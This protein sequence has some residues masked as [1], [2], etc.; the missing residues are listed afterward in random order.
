M[1]QK[2]YECYRYSDEIIVKS[3]DLK[4]HNGVMSFGHEKQHSTHN[5]FTIRLKKRLSKLSL[6]FCEQPEVKKTNQSVQPVEGISNSRTLSTL[7]TS[8]WNKSKK[9]L[10]SS[11][12]TVGVADIVMAKMSTYSPWPA[13][14]QNISTNKK[15]VSVYFF[16]DQTI[17]SVNSSEIV[18][19]TDCEAVIR[20]LLLRK[21]GPFHKSIS[22]VET[23]LNVPPKLSLLREIGA[24]Q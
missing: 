3:F 15:R 5:T 20:R 19:F 23:V 22:E 16:G 8:A 7:I 11:G 18:P 24:L 10:K 2:E 14:V 13:R 6:E 4:I 17:G 9:G 12:R 21:L 1:S